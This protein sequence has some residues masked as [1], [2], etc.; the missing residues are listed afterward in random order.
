MALPT[1]AN[2]QAHVVELVFDLRSA[3][4][5]LT[6]IVNNEISME[7]KCVSVTGLF[8]QGLKLTATQRHSSV[9][10]KYLPLIYLQAYAET[11]NADVFWSAR[12]M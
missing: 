11:D 7:I 9:P 1:I 2:C 4:G 5:A 12:L 6:L 8:E 3:K 10:C